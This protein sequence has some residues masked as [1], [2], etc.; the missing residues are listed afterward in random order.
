MA[1]RSAIRA[2]L[3]AAVEGV[4]PSAAQLQGFGVAGATALQETPTGQLVDPGTGQSHLL[5]LA[6]A[7]ASTPVE[8]GRGTEVVSTAY[9]VQVRYRVR[10][11]MDLGG[12]GDD[13]D[14]AS[15]LM[16]DL[17]AACL[18]AG[19][20]SDDRYNVSLA[21]GDDL[22]IDGPADGHVLIT[23]RLVAIHQ[24]GA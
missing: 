6:E 20:D 5:Y 19:G 2:A 10:G 23:I 12:I 13:I 21:E 18:I 15:D 11:G 9:T 3:K 1:R 14:D 7:G 16:E 8:R 24:L 22:T 4:T 17:A